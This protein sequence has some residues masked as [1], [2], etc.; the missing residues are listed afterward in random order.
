MNEKYPL[1]LPEGSVLAGQYVIE[2][3][4]GQGG[5]GITYEAKDHKSGERVAVKEFFPDAMATR[6][7]T[8]VMPFTGERGESFAYGKECFLQEAETLAKFIGNENIIRIRSYFEENGTAYFVMDFIE[9]TSFDD[10]IKEHGGKLSFEETKKILIPVMDALEIV[11]GKGIIHRDVTPDNIYITKDGTIK[12]L[13]FGA[14]RYS[15]GDKSRSLDVILKHGFAPKEQYTRRGKQG[16]FTDIYALGA[17]F[18]FALTG[19]R[20][21]D[22]VERMDEDE[23]IP[24][25]NLGVKISRE[26]EQAILTALNVQPQDRFQSMSAF[27]NALLQIKENDSSPIPKGMTSDQIDLNETVAPSVEQR[28]FSQTPEQAG[29]VTPEPAVTQQGNPAAGSTQQSVGTTQSAPGPEIKKIGKK[30]SGVAVK[31]LAVIGVIFVLMVIIGTCAFRSGETGALPAPDPQE[32]VAETNEGEEKAAAPETEPVVSEDTVETIAEEEPIVSED[33]VETTAKEESVVS[34]NTVETA[35][36]EEPEETEPEKTKPEAADIIGNTVNNLKNC[37]RWLLDGHYYSAT[38]DNT[39]MIDICLS[40]IGNKIYALSQKDDYAAVTYN[41]DGSQ[42]EFIPELEEYSD[43]YALMVSE[44]YYYIVDDDAMFYCIDRETGS[45][46]GKRQLMSVFSYAMYDGS[47][48]YINGKEGNQHLYAIRGDNLDGDPYDFGLLG[49]RDNDGTVDGDCYY[50]GVFY[51]ES[52]RIVVGGNATDYISFFRLNPY[53]KNAL[54]NADFWGFDVDNLETLIN[55]NVKG[56]N[57]YFSYMDDKNGYIAKES[58]DIRKCEVIYQCPLD[59][60]FGHGLSVLTQDGKE[61]I[62]FWKEEDNRTKYFILN[63]DG[64]IDSV[65]DTVVE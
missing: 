4:L 50:S 57:V 45:L 36:K 12:L 62:G 47:L 9:G 31:V 27:K 60:K 22:S 32:T 44:A 56:S 63:S 35:A 7:Q 30:V 28:V 3:V 21:P 29:A 15:L 11:H 2:K 55:M 25:G 24:P 8:T 23:L 41:L 52:N 65:L 58:L 54:K 19:K 43:I 42:V 20:P 5:F 37:S 18:Y 46:V 33:T 17:T 64:T 1:A 39:R 34:E 10:Y 6:Q 51:D 13:D 26:E 49:D 48:F 38:V 61:K 40:H 14:A 16:P 59:G 53:G